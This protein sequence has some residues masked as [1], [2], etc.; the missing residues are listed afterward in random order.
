MT[1]LGKVLSPVQMEG[2][3]E[4]GHLWGQKH[5]EQCTLV[6]RGFLE[7][8]P[9][10]VDLTKS[11]WLIQHRWVER[12]LAELYPITFHS[13]A[14]DLSTAHLGVRDRLVQVAL[15]ILFMVWGCLLVPQRRPNQER[16]QAKAR[17]MPKVVLSMQGFRCFVSAQGKEEQHQYTD[18]EVASYRVW[19]R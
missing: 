14:D 16:C 19:I 4:T 10:V 9:N 15:S 11:W 17:P 18:F 6:C 12:P 7:V 5:R 13:L 2:C 3:A 1:N 8:A